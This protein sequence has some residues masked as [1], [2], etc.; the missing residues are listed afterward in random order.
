MPETRVLFVDDEPNIRATLPEILRRHGYEVNV[1]ATVGEALAKIN[2]EQF[3]VL[4]SDLNIG[5]PGDGFAVV[6][7][8]RRIQPNC[9]NFILTGY[10]AFE[11]ALQALRSHVDDYLVKPAD[12]QGLVES[13]EAKLKAPEPRHALPL[14]RASTIIREHA[15]EIAKKALAKMKAHP[16]LA[17]IPLSD[18]ERLNDLPKMLYAIAEHLE[19]HPEETS[20]H[21]TGAAEHGRT[22][23]HQGYSIPWMIEDARCINEAIHGV[24]QD[25]LLALDVS[26]LIHD[27]WR[28]HNTLELQLEESLQAYLAV[29]KERRKQPSS[30]ALRKI[31]RTSG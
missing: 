28:V 18:E 11:T 16:Q 24:I 10:P 12:I 3:D 14:K 27:L 7:A 25:N 29:A 8:M 9:I 22:R 6:S 2:A 21:E 15:D 31:R 30:A 4:I 1:A 19:L 13:I 17:A 26:H 5:H 20:A 23:Q